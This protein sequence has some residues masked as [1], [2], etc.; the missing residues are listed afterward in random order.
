MKSS[1]TTAPGAFTNNLTEP[2]AA[3][4]FEDFRAYIQDLIAERRKSRRTDLLAALM[5]AR[6]DGDQL[7]QEELIATFMQLLWAG[8]ETT[9]NLIG[10]G[11][12]CL[13]D[14]QDQ[15]QRLLAEPELIKTAIEEYIVK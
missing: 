12:K 3:Q 11:L 15:K 4:A 13:L 14:A 7:T 8:H 2:L 6:E 9:T 10:N 5:D 1:V